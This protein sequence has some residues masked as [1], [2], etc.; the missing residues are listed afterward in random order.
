MRYKQ[1]WYRVN[2]KSALAALYISC[3]NVVLHRGWEHESKGQ[4]HQKEAEKQ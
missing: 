2:C 1:K 3:N 4:G